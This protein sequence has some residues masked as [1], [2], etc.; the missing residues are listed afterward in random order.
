MEFVNIVKQKVEIQTEKKE[1][2][3]IVK[4]KVEIKLE[5]DFKIKLESNNED[6]QNGLRVIENLN[7]P[8]DNKFDNSSQFL[9]NM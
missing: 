8:F 7:A 6:L 9:K 3:N 2:E 5:L 1:F 4:P